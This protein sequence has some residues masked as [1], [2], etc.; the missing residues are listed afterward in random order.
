MPKVLNDV[1]GRSITQEAL[2]DT[3][4]RE[5]VPVLREIRRAVNIIDGDTVK[6]TVALTVKLSDRRIFADA[7]AAAFDV[8]LPDPVVADD[9][10][11][12]IKKTDVSA[13]A[14]TVVAASIDGA[15]NYSLAAQYDGVHVH[16]VDGVYLITGVVP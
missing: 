7:T 9:Y 14:V 13:N 5:V 4:N 12:F 2:L 8:T 6:P 1:S 16:A 3:V 15:A 10:R 11:F